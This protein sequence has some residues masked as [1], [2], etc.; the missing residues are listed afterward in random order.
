MMAAVWRVAS[1]RTG[2]IKVKLVPLHLVDPSLD[3]DAKL[4]AVEAH[5]AILSVLT[6]YQDGVE[7]VQEGI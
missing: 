7:T 4:R 5:A 6:Y 1:R 2:T 3:D